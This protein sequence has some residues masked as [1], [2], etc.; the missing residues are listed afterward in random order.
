M[1]NFRFPIAAA[2]CRALATSTTAQTSCPMQTTQH[3][4]ETVS[5][6]PTQDCG[7]LDYSLIEVSG[8]TGKGTCPTF[9]LYTPP[10]DVAVPAATMTYV[11][12]LQTLP[13][14]LVTFECHTRWLL[15]LPIGSNC[16]ASQPHNVGF[17]QSMIA[18]P[19]QT[20]QG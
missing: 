9:L 7:S 8:R 15:F 3:V 17:V 13:V 5:L 6:G 16:A 19:C 1:R 14:T 12:V 20:P 10:H 4:A 18:R 11:D 2:V